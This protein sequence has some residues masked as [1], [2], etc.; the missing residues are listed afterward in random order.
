MTIG[1]INIQLVAELKSM[2]QFGGADA[3]FPELSARVMQL[4]N[5]LTQRSAGIWSKWA[6]GIAVASIL[7]TLGF[8]IA[9]YYSDKSWQDNQLKILYKIEH[10][11][12]I[13]KR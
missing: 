10:N 3:V 11:T 5:E 4:Q 9:N 7:V 1:E 2:E 13:I 8:S 6:I 12:N